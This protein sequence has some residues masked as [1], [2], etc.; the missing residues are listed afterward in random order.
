MARWSMAS[1]RTSSRWR[2]C[3]ELRQ[4]TAAVA[5]PPTADVRI[6]RHREWK[7]RVVRFVNASLCVRI[8]LRDIEQHRDDYR[9]TWWIR[10]ETEPTMRADLVGLGVQLSWIEE[11]APEEQAVSAVLDRMRRES[12][13]ILLIYDNAMSARWRFLKR[14][15]ALIIPIR[16]QVSTISVFCCRRRATLPERGHTMSARWTSLRKSSDPP[17]RTLRR[18]QRRSQP[19]STN[20][21]FQTKRP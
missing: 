19:Y 4:F 14:H 3:S 7:P 11:D 1:I 13:G 17:I 9:A 12:Q 2:F 8:C 10:A 20:S 6:A 15:W 16:Q 21:S 5:G 18:W